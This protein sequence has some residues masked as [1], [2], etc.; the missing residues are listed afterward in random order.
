MLLCLCVY[1]WTL[2]I[3]PPIRELVPGEDWF[4]LSPQLLISLLVFI[5]RGGACDI[6]PSILKCQ[7]VL[8]L[9][10]SY[11]GD[12]TVDISLVQFLCH[13]VFYEMVS[14]I[15]VVLYHYYFILIFIILTQYIRTSAS[16][17]NST[18]NSH[19]LGPSASLFSFRKEQVSKVVSTEL[20]ITR[21]NKTKRIP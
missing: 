11:L 2:R 3:R 7:L 6:P 21:C 8:S 5:N 13:D 18:S 4:S 15:K 17:S 1:S 10:K 19:F 16:L 14:S 12:Y 20:H 9:C